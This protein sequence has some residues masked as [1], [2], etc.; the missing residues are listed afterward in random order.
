M[1]KKIINLKNKIFKNAIPYIAELDSIGLEKWF[2]KWNLDKSEWSLL[3]DNP[4]CGIGYLLERPIL[5]AVEN[6]NKDPE[7]IISIYKVLHKYVHWKGFDNGEYNIDLD[8]V[9]DVIDY[10]DVLKIYSYLYDDTRF[11]VRNFSPLARTLFKKV[12]KNVAIEFI[13]KYKLKISTKK[14]ITTGEISSIVAQ[15]SIEL[16]SDIKTVIKFLLDQGCT[17]GGKLSVSDLLDWRENGLSPKGVGYLYKLLLSKGIEM[18]TYNDGNIQGQVNLIN[19]MIGSGLEAILTD[20]L[21]RAT[22]SDVFDTDLLSKK[23]YAV[24]KIRSKNIREILGE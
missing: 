5:A 1:D 15:N 3:F 19:R 21:K 11:E 4:S 24:I 23:Q 7:A 22:D 20:V 14:P 12:D 18:Q 8:A 6:C 9:I 16:L 13:E 2:E 10:I 17:F